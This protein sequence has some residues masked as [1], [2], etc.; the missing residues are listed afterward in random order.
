V[1]RQL[2]QTGTAK[3]I[4]APMKMTLRGDMIDRVEV[5]IGTGN[6]K[7]VDPAY[8]DRILPRVHIQQATADAQ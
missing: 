8:R 3:E 2:K 7:I 1:V 5:R 4:D 6:V